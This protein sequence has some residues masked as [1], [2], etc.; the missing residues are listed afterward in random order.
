M[1]TD[2]PIEAL[3]GALHAACLRDLPDIP[4]RDRDWE[5]HRKAM[6]ALTKE[7]KAALYEKERST[8]QAE[9]PF[10][11]RTRRPTPHGCSVVMFPQTWGSTALGFGG[12]GGQA[13]TNAY[14]I[15]VECDHTGYRAVYFGGGKLA[16]LG[17]PAGI[18]GTACAL[19]AGCGGPTPRVLLRCGQGLWRGAVCQGRGQ[20]WLRS[21]ESRT[22]TTPTTSGGVVVR[23]PAPA[24]TIVLRRRWTGARAAVTSGLARG[25]A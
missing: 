15:I 22:S 9:G 19:H 21:P 1:S 13:I 12:I 4:Y 6:D 16:Y 24:A 17:A 3:A 7:E 5:A 2:Y 23:P 18:R 11:E 14:T 20:E 8:G 10:I 25:R